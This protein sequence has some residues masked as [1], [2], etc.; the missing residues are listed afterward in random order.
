MNQAESVV[1]KVLDQQGYRVR[2]ASAADILGQSVEELASVLV[3]LGADTVED[4]EVVSFQDLIGSVEG[5]KPTKVRRA[6]VALKDSTAQE[7]AGNASE[8]LA[9][10]VKGLGDETKLLELTD[11]QPL[12]CRSGNTEHSAANIRHY[13]KVSQVPKVCVSCGELLAH[14]RGEVS[15]E[16]GTT[17][18]ASSGTNPATG[19]DE[20]RFAL[21]D[22]AI[23]YVLIRDRKLTPDEAWRRL[24]DRSLRSHFR[25]D[26]ARLEGDTPNYPQLLLRELK[27]TRKGNDPFFRTRGTDGHVTY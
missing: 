23:A 24:E 13:R 19:R 27:G 15:F 7:H 25:V 2:V 16:D 20:G 18:L 9:D 10:L 6:L 21:A 12:L 22:R 8:N 26:V 1:Q 11:G 5:A 17:F 3:G 14:V 4:L